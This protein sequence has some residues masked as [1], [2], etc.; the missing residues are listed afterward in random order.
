[1][2]GGAKGKTEKGFGS[3]FDKVTELQVARNR[4]TD[5]NKL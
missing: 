2:E 3:A 4:K 1:M 5:E